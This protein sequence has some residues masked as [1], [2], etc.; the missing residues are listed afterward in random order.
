MCGSLF[1]LKFEHLFAFLC[2]LNLKVLF[3]N[4]VPVVWEIDVGLC[5]VVFPFSLATYMDRKCIC[6]TVLAMV[7]IKEKSRMD[8]SCLQL[9]S[10]G[11]MNLFLGFFS[12]QYEIFN[13]YEGGTLL[14]RKSIQ[15]Y[16]FL[17]FYRE[18]NSRAHFISTGGV[19]ACCGSGTERTHV[20][21]R[22]PYVQSSAVPQHFQA[23]TAD[24]PSSA[25][26]R[27]FRAPG[28]V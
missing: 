11:V 9:C 8:A 20:W 7:C 23:P 26:P 16:V 5:C 12:N 21:R 17:V 4:P 27:N 15:H 10:V 19:V 3:V 13:F 22:T 2:L 28:M 24:F 14:K 6:I 25:V 1:S 18:G